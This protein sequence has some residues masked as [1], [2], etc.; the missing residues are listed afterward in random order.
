[1]RISPKV[2]RQSREWSITLVMIGVLFTFRSSLADWYDVPSGSMEPTILVG[3]RVVVNKL[4]YG[5]KVPFTRLRVATW[6]EPVRGDIVTFPSP[7]DGQRLVKRV[8]AVAGDVV[9]MR[10]GRLVLD[11]TPLVYTPAPAPAWPLRPD[12]GHEHGWFTEDLAGRAHPVMTTDRGPRLRNWGPVE[13]P[14][15]SVLVLGDNR[16]NSADGR[17]FGF[18][19]SDQLEGRVE[20]VAFSLDRDRHWGPRW[21]R[22][23]DG[24]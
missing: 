3:D 7:A 21:G 14:A 8:V 9:A 16:D 10:D 11:G 24:L 18:V 20:G 22:F 12:D 19:P 13:V 6:A 1:M 2:R 15:G 17:V 4:A 23:G 5:L